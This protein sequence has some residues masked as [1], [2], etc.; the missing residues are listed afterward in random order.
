M[1]RLAHS[2]LCAV[3]LAG[4]A[5]AQ[6]TLGSSSYEGGGAPLSGGSFELRGTG[7]THAGEGFLAGG[8]I[9]H[10]GGHWP[11]ICGSTVASYG[12]GCPGSGGFVPQIG[13]TGCF[14]ASDTTVLSISNGLGGSQAFVMY[15]FGQ[16]AVPLGAGCLLRIAVLAPSPVGPL[17]LF[18]AG[19]GGGAIALPILLPPSLVTAWGISLNLQAFVVDPGA[20]LGFVATNG[21]QATIG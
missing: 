15:G 9:A 13:M 8:T 4:A 6:F 7:G 20:P 5:H 16:A 12:T 21:V 18:G 2:F 10:D 1:K 14:A 3:V 19:A 17:P 11:A